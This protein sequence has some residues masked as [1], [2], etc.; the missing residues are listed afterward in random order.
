ML[1]KAIVGARHTAQSITW[2]DQDGNARSLSGATLTGTI[3]D[4]NGDTR[5]IDG[6]LTPDADQVTNIGIFTW[7]YGAIDVGTAGEFLVEF[8]ATYTNY[9]LTFA[10]YWKVETA[11]PVATFPFSYDLDAAVGQIRL[12]IGDTDNTADAGVKPDGTN[13]SD[14]ELNHF[15]SQEGSD[16][17]AASARACEVLAR[18]WAR[19]AKSVKIRDYSIDTRSQAKYFK[20]LGEELRKRT[21]S[22]YAGGSVPTTRVDGYSN[23][24]HSQQVESQSEYYQ[25][26]KE[27]KW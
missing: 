23:D 13:F 15:Y 11:L 26:R 18:M 5:A 16:V 8:K 17:L 20:E 21:G 10:T 3:Q 9:D 14:A 4:K 25:E 1:A 2:Q 27:I 22:L 24:Q 6:T 19:Q 12:E 7:A